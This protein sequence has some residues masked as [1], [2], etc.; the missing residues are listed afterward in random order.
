MFGGWEDISRH[1]YFVFVLFLKSTVGLTGY[2]QVSAVVIGKLSA[3]QKK[4]DTEIENNLSRKG[5]QDMKKGRWV[6]F[7]G[8]EILNEEPEGSTVEIQC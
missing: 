1:D 4:V 6:K 7:K 5:K 3:F 2:D 8:Y